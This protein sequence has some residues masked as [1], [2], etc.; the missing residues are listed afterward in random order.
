MNDEWLLILT[1]RFSSLLYFLSLYHCPSSFHF[2]PRVGG[3]EVQ[4]VFWLAKCP[5]E[6][7]APDSQNND[8]FEPWTV[9]RKGY[10]FPSSSIRM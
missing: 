7:S 10:K 5:L 8:H 1:Q 3:D 9:L 6:I 4:H 2:A